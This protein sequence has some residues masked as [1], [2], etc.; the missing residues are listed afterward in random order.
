M[1]LY[2]SVAIF[3]KHD[4]YTIGTRLEQNTL[5][6]LELFVLAESKDGQSKLLILKKGDVNIKILKLLIRMAYE[7]KA[8]PE[9]K[10]LESEQRLL[11]IGRRLGGWIK[12][13]KSKRLTEEPL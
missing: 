7:L 4:R 5:E 9:Y 2:H 8:L 13:V 10:Y 3:P 1:Y 11:E 12:L 6:L